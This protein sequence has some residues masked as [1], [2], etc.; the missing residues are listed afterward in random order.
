VKRKS[1]VISH[2]QER[3]ATGQ[4]EKKGFRAN[5]LIFLYKFCKQYFNFAIY[6][7]VKNFIT[8]TGKSKLK[9]CS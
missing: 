9:A 5:I 2:C 1:L 6:K 3:K 4:K 8:F 7:L